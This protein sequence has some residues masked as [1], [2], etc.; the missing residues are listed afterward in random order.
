M[1]NYVL[2]LSLLVFVMF[3]Y[4]LSAMAF[5]DFVPSTRPAFDFNSGGDTG[6]Q[7]YMV[8]GIAPMLGGYAGFEW[9]YAK[10]GGEE[11]S[12]HFKARAEV[13]KHWK[14]L[15]GYVYARYGKRSTMAQDRLLQGGLALDLKLVDSEDLGVNVGLGSYA[16]HELLE[17]EYQAIIEN[18]SVEIAPR[19]HL[20]LRWQHVV[21]LNEVFLSEDFE[22]YRTRTHVEIRI[23]IAKL[24]FFERFYL[25][26]S[27][28]AEYDSRTKHI[29]I[30]S[31]Q[32]NWAHRLQWEF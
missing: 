18:A 16:E 10:D 1:K 5:A 21:V 12:N 20:N 14:W 2:I 19:C 29:D 25:V 28:D 9:R 30:E 26:V 4:F 31:F 15:G 3:A 13:L 8:R 11:S 22:R 7:H 27:G 6:H 32:W 23:P 24:F 17:A